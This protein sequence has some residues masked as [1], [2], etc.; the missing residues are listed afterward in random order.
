MREGGAHPVAL[1]RDRDGGAVVG[2]EACAGH[3]PL[4]EDR[5]GAAPVLEPLHPVGRRSSPHG[6][7]SPRWPNALGEER[8]T[9]QHAGDR[10]GQRRRSGEPQAAARRPSRDRSIAAIS[11]TSPSSEPELRPAAGGEDDAG[12]G[13]R[14]HD[15]AQGCSGRCAWAAT[16]NA[17]QRAGGQEDAGLVVPV[18]RALE[19][20]G[21]VLQAPPGQPAVGELAGGGDQDRAEQERAA[22]RRTWPTRRPPVR[23]ARRRRRRPPRA[24]RPSRSEQ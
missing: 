10:H 21:R 15:P 1:C 17:Q 24:S 6:P 2:V 9:G 23:A 11:R 12:G 16:A 5:D 3:R 14:G 4:G 19:Q 8:R 20:L 13:E 22:R 18:E 7:P